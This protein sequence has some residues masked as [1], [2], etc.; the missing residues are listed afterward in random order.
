MSF[1][2]ALSDLDTA[3]PL[4]RHRAIV[5]PEWINANSHMNVAYYVL[6]FDQATDTFCE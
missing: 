5:R 1:P 4:D 3:A 6:A 2:Y